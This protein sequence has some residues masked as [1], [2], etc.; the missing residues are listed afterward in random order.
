ME[1]SPTKF[2]IIKTSILNLKKP[3]DVVHTGLSDVDPLW[4][5]FFQ[6]LSL[7]KIISILIL[8]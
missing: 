5:S 6:T 7:L 3:W 8:Y 2:V 1:I 4:I